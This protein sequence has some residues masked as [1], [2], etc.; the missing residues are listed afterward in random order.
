[1]YLRMSVL[2]YGNSINALLERSATNSI[3]KSP[4]Q[5][6]NSTPAAGSKVLRWKDMEVGIAD[7][8]VRSQPSS[9]KSV[10][11]TEEGEREVLGGDEIAMCENDCNEMEELFI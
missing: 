10:F 11:G 3:L 1:M 8:V 7:P 4:G 5:S 9:V 2:L 6:G